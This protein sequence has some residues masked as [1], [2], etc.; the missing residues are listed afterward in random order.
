MDGVQRWCRVTV[1]GPDGVELTTRVLEG[2]SEPDLA[3][4]DEVARLT[5]LARRRGG[6]IILTELAPAL[7]ELLELTG[8]PIEMKR[9]AELREQPFGVEEVEEEAHPGDLAP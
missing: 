5:L 8:L 2:P 7:Q 3:T 1:L 9:E 6:G 4:V